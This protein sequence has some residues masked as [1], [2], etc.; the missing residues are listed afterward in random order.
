[1]QRRG[2]SGWGRGFQGG[3]MMS[4]GGRGFQDRRMGR[5]PGPRF[6]G[7]KPEND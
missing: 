4:R 6:P 3:S 7:P 2:M 5:R 1:M